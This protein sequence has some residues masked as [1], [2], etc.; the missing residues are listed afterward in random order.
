MAE[1]IDEQARFGL[2]EVRRFVAGEY[3][4]MRK[5]W[6]LQIEINEHSNLLM[7]IIAIASILSLALSIAALVIAMKGV[8]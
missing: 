7:L 5:M 2:R 8:N 1:I 4:E 3:K 6:R